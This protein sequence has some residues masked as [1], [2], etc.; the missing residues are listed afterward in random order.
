MAISRYE[1]R[2]ILQNSHPLYEEF[3]LERRVNTFTQY[4]TPTYRYLTPSE[5]ANLD[6][7]TRYWSVG[8]RF[9][10]FAQEFYGDPRLWWLIA[11]FNKKPTESHFK[12]GDKIFIPTPL[13]DILL[14]FGL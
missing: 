5:M 6:I 4:D 12:A 13:E 10:K 14:F 9:Y 8:D 2:K 11:W 7:I 3:R 1:D